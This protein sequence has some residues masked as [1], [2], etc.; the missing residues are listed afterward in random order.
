MKTISILRH[1]KS[2]WEQLNLGDI[3]RP[4]LEKGITKTKKVCKSMIDKGLVPDCI[5]TSPAARAMQTA[6]IVIEELKLS[7]K[8]Q[9]SKKLYPGRI[10]EILKEISQFGKGVE[11]AMI[12]GHNP[13]FTDLVLH[14]CN[15]LK[16]DWLPTS[17]LVNL[18]FKVE[19]WQSIMEVKGKCVHYITP[20]DI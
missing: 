11:H 17:G 14:L 18:E 13:V 2:S 6:H 9:I 5:I 19:D 3:D 1:G 7:L 12:V 20:K 16:I 4:L 8:P 15:D 10:E